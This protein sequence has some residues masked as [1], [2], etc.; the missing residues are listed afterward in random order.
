MSSKRLLIVGGAAAATALT[1]PA[2]GVGGAAGVRANGPKTGP[3]RGT[4]QTGRPT[5]LVGVTR[6]TVTVD[7]HCRSTRKLFK[8]TGSV[9]LHGFRLR[10]ASPTG[11]GE[12][13]YV[14]GHFTGPLDRRGHYTQIHGQI[15]NGCGTGTVS[16]HATHL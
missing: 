13:E 2:A 6:K 16:W 7:E 12:P 4:D 1:G 14:T 11:N 10:G 15:N 3:Y 5:I 9:T 8:K